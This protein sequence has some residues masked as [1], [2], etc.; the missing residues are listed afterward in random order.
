MWIYSHSLTS[1]FSSVFDISN[2]RISIC[3]PF[4]LIFYVAPGGN[5]SFNFSLLYVL[6]AAQKNP[7]FLISLNSFFSY[8]LYPDVCSFFYEQHFFDRKDSVLLSSN[9]ISI[10][11]EHEASLHFIMVYIIPYRTSMMELFYKII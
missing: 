7:H 10:W 6:F 11:P 1:F 4:P 2:Q 8:F 9:I 3:L 5:L